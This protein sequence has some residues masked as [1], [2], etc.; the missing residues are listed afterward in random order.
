MLLNV[1][2]HKRS[3][4]FLLILGGLVFGVSAGAEIV[5][6]VTV[7]E[8][9]LRIVDSPDGGSSYEALSLGSDGRG[10]FSTNEIYIAPGRSTPTSF[11]RGQAGTINA[12]LYLDSGT[13]GFSAL[14]AVGDSATNPVLVAEQL[15]SGSYA[16]Y[17]DGDVI[18]DGGNLEVTKSKTAKVRTSQGEVYLH[19]LESPTVKFTDYGEG[20]LHNGTAQVQL[21]P[22]FMETIEGEYHVFITALGDPTPLAVSEQTTQ[23]FIVSGARDAAFIYEIVGTR[24]GFDGR[25]F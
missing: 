16:G 3:L 5:K 21:D 4:L 2:S 1:T 23:G 13:A 20:M 25:R 17:F 7:Y 9:A 11:F 24:K 14:E 19:A 15:A 8:G 10:I 22:R 12:G 6:R 18:V